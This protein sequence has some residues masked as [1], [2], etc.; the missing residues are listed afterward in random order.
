MAGDD[1]VVDHLSVVFRSRTGAH[2]AGRDAS[3]S[4]GGGRMVGLV[5]ESGSGKTATGLALLGLH[6]PATTTVGGSARFG[7]TEL[8]GLAPAAARKLRGSMVGMIFQDPMTALNP[9][10]TIGTQVT[11]T[12]RVHEG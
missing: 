12:I 10:L 7:E 9:L 8:L 1:L 2:A 3:F 4:V 6:D 11:E 5:G